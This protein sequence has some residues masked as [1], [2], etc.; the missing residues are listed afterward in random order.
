MRRDLE[1]DLHPSLL[2]SRYIDGFTLT[3]PDTSAGTY[4]MLR[5]GAMCHDHHDYF[6]SD[7]DSF[8][9]PSALHRDRVLCPFVLP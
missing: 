6:L 4:E 3:E 9:T 7:L 2:A 5:L 8:F 1:S